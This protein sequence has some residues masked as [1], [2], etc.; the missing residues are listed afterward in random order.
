MFDKLTER[1]AGAVDALRGRGR[2]TDDNIA[3]TLRQVRMALIEAD[4]AVPVVKTFVDAVRARAIGAEVQKSLTPGQVFIKVLHD[5]LVAVMGAPGQGLGL[6]AE[7][8]VVVLLAGLQGAGKTTTS[9]KL[10]RLLMAERKKRV[11]LVST[12]IYRPAAITQLERL[13]AQVGA[14]FVGVESGEQPVAIAT[15]ALAEARRGL[16]DVLIVDTAGR[17]HVDGEMMGEVRAI[18]AAVRPHERLFVVD[19]MAGQDAVNAARAFNEALDL[20]GVIL[21]KA[22]GDARGGA[23]LSVRQVTGKPILYVGVGEKVEALELFHPDRVASRIL[24]MG[25]VV[26]LVE[27]VQRDVDQHKAAELQKKLAKGKG[28][29]F[30]DLREQMLQL[31]KM[32]GIG[33]LVDKLPGRLSQAAGQASGQ[34]DPRQVRRQIAMINSMTPKERRKPDLIDGSRKRRIANGSGVQVQDVNR[35]LKQFLQ[36]Q[37]VMKQFSKGGIRGMMRSLGGRLP[38]GFG[39]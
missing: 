3:D 20:T 28:F 35:L 37:K 31:E 32:G 22:D 19:G 2:L 14:G 34:F 10:A 33:A 7:P 26:S 29:D 27:Q 8:P 6:R 38:P 13:A 17:L 5:E 16:Y 4:V 36:M 24:G 30:N 18:D 11:L 15:R 1:L 23:A 12:D 25:D 39:P 9:A 21:T